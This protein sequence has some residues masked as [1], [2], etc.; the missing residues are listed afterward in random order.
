MSGTVTIPKELWHHLT[1]I[2]REQYA[3][4]GFGWGTVEMVN[5]MTKVLESMDKSNDL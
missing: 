1:E 2:A 3:R 4:T 5:A